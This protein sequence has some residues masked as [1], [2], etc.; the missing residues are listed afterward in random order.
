MR[1]WQ[2]GETGR[3]L[4]IDIQMAPSKWVELT[5]EQYEEAE[6]HTDKSVK[7]TPY[8]QSEEPGMLDFVR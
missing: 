3:L 8:E 1:Y 4:A 5:K 2:H 7:P 6:K